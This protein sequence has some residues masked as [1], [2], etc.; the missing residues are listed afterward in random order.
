MLYAAPSATADVVA[1]AAAGRFDLVTTD[2]EQVIV[3]GQVL[4]RP[5]ASA[6]EAAARK[7]AWGRRAVQRVL[8]LTTRQLQQSEL[9]DVTGIS[10]QSVSLA[11]RKLSGQVSRTDTGWSATEGTLD[12]WVGDYPGPRGTVSYWY[13]LDSPTEQATAALGL[14]DE[15]ELRAVVSGDL[16]A[17]RYSPWQLPASVRV[18]LPE[19][20]DFTVVGFSPAEP[21]DA[22]MTVVVP[23]DPTILT[24]ATKLGST[25]SGAHLLADAAITLWDLLN[26]STATTAAEAA[27]HLRAAIATGAFGV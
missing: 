15:L 12:R 2:P 13:G 27:D 26:T 22:T 19:I 16:A 14:L 3:D 25:Y 6:P 8:A 5:E 7:P 20:V 4:L 10:Q 17:D 24:M 21:E 11:L 18:Y 23:E 9:A 1:A